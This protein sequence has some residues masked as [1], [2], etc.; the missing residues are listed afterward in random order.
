MVRDE[1]GVNNNKRQ[2]MGES[3]SNGIDGRLLVNR[4]LYKPGRNISLN[5]SGGYNDSESESYSRNKIRY[6]Q[7]DGQDFTNQYILQP[8]ESHNVSTRLSYSEPIIGAL[9][10]QLSYQFQYRYSDSD[11]SMYSINELVFHPLEVP[12]HCSP[13]WL[14]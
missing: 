14:F 8:S 10:M 9:N 2:G 7:R 1:I 13:E 11:R 4:R 3:R 12:G 6:F 5:V